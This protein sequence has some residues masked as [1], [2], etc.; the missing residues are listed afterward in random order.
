MEPEKSYSR[1]GSG[2]L[3]IY[4]APEKRPSQKEMHHLPTINFQERTVSFREG[5]IN[6]MFQS[7]RCFSCFFVEIPWKFFTAIKLN[8]QTKP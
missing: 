5:Y 6:Q 1:E 4:I 8:H 2:F 3:G 7:D